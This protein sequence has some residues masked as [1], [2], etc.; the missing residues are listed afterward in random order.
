MPTPDPEY[1]EHV[2]CAFVDALREAEEMTDAGSFGAPLYD[3]LRYASEL[4][5][6][7]VEELGN[8][9]HVTGEYAGG[10]LLD[11]ADKLAALER[12]LPNA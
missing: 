5:D 1:L 10:R 12:L 7:M 11:L 9:R 8:A 4:H 3:V 6:I 2:T